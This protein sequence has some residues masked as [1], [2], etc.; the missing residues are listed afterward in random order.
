MSPNDDSKTS[1]LDERR[2]TTFIAS[3]RMH[4]ENDATYISPFNKEVR[5]DIMVY[6]SMNERPV[7][8]PKITN[9]I[10]KKYMRAKKKKVAKSSIKQF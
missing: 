6:S 2:K 8:L 1:L 10:E 7:N 3:P 9:V 4:T 5:N